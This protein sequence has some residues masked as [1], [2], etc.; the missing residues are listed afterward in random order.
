MM[1][2]RTFC[3]IKPNATARHLEDEINNK[4][5]ETGLNIIASKRVEQPTRA[6]FE[7]FYAEHKGKSFY[8]G[9]LEFM[10]SG[11]IVVQVL[12][13]EDAIQRY[14]T[15]MGKTDPAEAAEG[16][17]RKLYAESKTKNS[18]H[19]SDSP[20]SAAREISLWFSEDELK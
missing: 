11:P 12:E 16:T 14:R 3:I 7:A 15:L 6:Q 8:E 9:L 19:G 5:R 1:L 4:I 2:E 13:G 10:T 20:E 18:V 17:L